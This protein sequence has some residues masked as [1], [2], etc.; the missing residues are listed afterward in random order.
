MEAAWLE[1]A[2]FSAFEIRHSEDAGQKM[3][4][5]M[6]DIATCPDC[7]AE[8][9]LPGDRRFGYPFTNCTNCGPRFSIIQAL[10]YD[11]PNTTMRRFGL[12][13]DCRREYENPADRRF[14]AQ[15]TACPECGPHLELVGVT[16]GD[17]DAIRRTAEA[18]RAGLIVAVKGLGGFHL[19][20]DARNGLAV[21]RLRE[22]KPRRDKPFAVMARDLEQAREICKVSQEAATLLLSP[23]APILLLPRRMEP[24]ASLANEI[25]P[26]NPNLGVMVPYTPLHHLLL[27]EFGYPV[28]ATSGNLS[29]EPICTDEDEGLQRL[30]GIADLFL[31]HDRPI[32]RHVDDSVAWIVRGEPRLL[33]RA[34]GYA[35]LP[36]PLPESVPAILATGGHLKNTVALSVGSEAFISQHIGDLE[37]TEAMDAFERVIADFLRLYETA[38]AAIAHDLHPD[39]AS[40]RWALE[41]AAGETIRLCAV[42]HHHAHL[43]S[44]LADNGVAGLRWVSSGMGPAMGLTG[45]CG[46]ANSCSAMQRASHASRICA[47]FACRAATPLCMNRAA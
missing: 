17:T 47:R 23:E 9:L 35:P 25:A 1:P 26:G 7:L 44:C 36:V 4:L 11:R 45:Q 21:A 37:T 27:R 46:E 3:A 14:H 18:L 32:A 28:V 42:Q 30:A 8:I 13:P 33:R 43:A 10:P 22:R 12:C 19:M 40:T 16:G 39:Y 5:V 15:P 20:V 41:R 38:P 29:D 31:V 2:G 6:P 24:G 34:R